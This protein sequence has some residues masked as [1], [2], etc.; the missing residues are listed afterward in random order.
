MYK[1]KNEEVAT[2][3]TSSGVGEKKRRDIPWAPHFESGKVLTFT[4]DMHI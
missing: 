1:N 2:M 3:P 4:I